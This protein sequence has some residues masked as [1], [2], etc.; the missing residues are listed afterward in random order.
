MSESGEADALMR[1][2]CSLLD[3]FDHEGA[4]RIGKRLETMRYTGAFEIQALAHAGMGDIPHAI[5]VLE[6][7]VTKGP[8]VW[9]LWQLLGNYRSDLGRFS[10][11]HAAYE[12]ALHCPDVDRSCVF[13]NI[14]TVLSREGRFDRALEAL[15]QVT[16]PALRSRAAALRL[17][18]LGQRGG[19]EHVIREGEQLLAALDADADAEMAAAIEIE[20]GEAYLRGRRDQ[21]RAAELAMSALARDRSSRGALALLR[22]VDSRFSQRAMYYRLLIEGDWP[23]STCDRAPD[24]HGFFVTYDVVADSIDEALTFVARL[25]PQ[26]VRATLR[27]SE[28]EALEPRPTE[29]K[30]VYR[31]TG[32]HS[33]RRDADDDGDDSQHAE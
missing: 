32:Y 12:R 24:E 6:V 28:S 19:H 31:R 10:E 17:S 16:S 8:N 11:A 13:L 27:L 33:F 29:P 15:G 20:V 25:E 22:D 18:I 7:G 3:A 4:L 2:A 5:A 14:A 9:L 23:R 1:E 26:H 21:Q 30:G